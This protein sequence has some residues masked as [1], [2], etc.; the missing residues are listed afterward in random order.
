ML[1]TETAMKKMRE[2]C[3]TLP[4]ASERP[5]FGESIFYVGKKGFASCGEKDGVCRFVFQLEPA[6]TEEL[7]RTD[8]R[9]KRYPY[10]KQCLVLDAADAK[11]WTEVKALVLESY[12]LIASLAP[13]VKPATKKRA[14]PKPRRV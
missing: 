10:A 14:Q 7:L 4:D 8:K 12:H 13:A 11:S 3:R 5:H 2:L 9:L 1:T 6:H